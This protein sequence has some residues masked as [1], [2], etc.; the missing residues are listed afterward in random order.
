MEEYYDQSAPSSTFVRIGS[1]QLTG[2]VTSEVR[3]RPLNRIIANVTFDLHAFDDLN[4]Q[5]RSLS[6]E[7]LAKTGRTGCTTDELY[8]LLSSYFIDK[9]RTFL[10]AAVKDVTVGSFSDEG[11]TTVREARKLFAS[12]SHALKSYAGDAGKKKGDSLE[13][14]LA[15]RLEKFGVPS[16]RE[17]LSALREL[18]TSAARSI[19]ARSLA[20]TQLKRLRAAY[21][22]S[23]DDGNA[24]DSAALVYKT[25]SRSINEKECTDKDSNGD[26]ASGKID[27]VEET[28]IIFPDW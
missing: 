12:A 11:S 3:S 20:G 18:S 4:V 25:R 1:I 27:E 28:I 7:N 16:S 23:K 5:I 17:K 24:L 14:K 21:E 6:E 26:D 9:L 8:N 2:N 10:S 22:R 19:D 13:E 15:S